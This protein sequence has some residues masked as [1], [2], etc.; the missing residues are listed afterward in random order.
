MGSAV[1]RQG[2]VIGSLVASLLLALLFSIASTASAQWG[3]GWRVP[4]R[5]PPAEA[6][7]RGF[8][9]CRIMYQQVRSE[10]LGHGWNTD[11]PNSDANLMIR[12][13]ELTKTTISQDRHGEP[14]FYVV[15]LTLDEVFGCPFT[16]MSDVGTVGFTADEVEQLRAY[17]LKGGFLW[18]DDFWGPQAWDH[19]VG[20]ISR[21]L[22]PGEYPIFDVPI[23]HAI[24]RGL[25]KVDDVPQIPS[26][27]YWRRSGGGTSEQGYSSAEPHFRSIAD[28]HSRLMVVMSHNTDI[29]DGWEREGEDHEFFHR[30]S[31]DSYA[32]AIDVLL[33]AMS[34]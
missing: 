8:S 19:W 25:F 26:I 13:S 15:R 16:F 23:D 17:L 29:A 24:F 22:P 28:E 6:S 21:V 3:W 5:F 27:Q 1:G 11:Y 33:Y 10:Y 14:N 2:F 32:V 9:F 12:L 18:V 7:D 4:P 34:H 30:F 20:Q 31:I